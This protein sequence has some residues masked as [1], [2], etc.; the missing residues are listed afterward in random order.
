[1]EQRC[2]RCKQ[3]KGVEEFSPSYRGKDGT[4]CRACFAAYS[5]GERGTTVPHQP[6]QCVRCGSAFVPKQLKAKTKYC[7][8]ECKEAAARESGQTRERHLLRKYGITIADYEA[9]L[10]AQGGGCAI[11]GRRPE[12]QKRYPT[13][14]HVDHCHDTGRVRGLLCDQHNLLL[15]RFDHDPALLRRAADYLEAGAAS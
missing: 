10:H 6:L 12:E 1:M 4:W 13:F 8:R 15:G 14:L 2:G 11:C 5:R 9:M 3:R 7:S